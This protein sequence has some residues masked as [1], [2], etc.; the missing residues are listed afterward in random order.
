MPPDETP[1]GAPPPPLPREIL[2]IQ[3][4]TPI[5]LPATTLHIPAFLDLTEVEGNLSVGYFKLFPSN[6]RL[7]LSIAHED[8]PNPFAPGNITVTQPA[9]LQYIANV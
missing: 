7:R 1:D 6:Q 2:I 9:I 8:R 5:A 3:T 4:L